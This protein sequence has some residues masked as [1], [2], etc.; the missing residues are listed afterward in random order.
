MYV[1]M[2]V[3]YIC[4]Y[5]YIYREREREIPVYLFT[6]DYLPPHPRDVELGGPHG[7]P[8][9]FRKKHSMSKW[10]SCGH[11]TMDYVIGQFEFD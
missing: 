5:I 1:C 9:P 7:P 10:I 2:Y 4:M 3:Y 11:V 6:S 8:P